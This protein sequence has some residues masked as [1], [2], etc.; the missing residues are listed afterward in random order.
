MPF[1]L[2]ILNKIKEV[3]QE[4]RDII[5]KAVIEAENIKKGITQKSIAANEEAFN[6]EIAQA[7]KKAEELRN[8]SRKSI[9]QEKE[10]ILSNAEQQSKDIEIKVETNQDKAVN[11]VLDIIISSGGEK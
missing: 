3:Q 5:N 4:A 9:K 8:N 10:Q 6:A 11:Y 7:E 2:E 1:M